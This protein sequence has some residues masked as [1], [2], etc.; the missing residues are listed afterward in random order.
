MVFTLWSMA[1]KL[2][3]WPIS[4]LIRYRRLLNKAKVTKSPSVSELKDHLALSA[5]EN[6]SCSL[7]LAP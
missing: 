6:N 1:Y 5:S 3:I 7:L 4:L 2:D